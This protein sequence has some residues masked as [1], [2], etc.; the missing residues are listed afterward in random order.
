MYELPKG[1]KT[2]V[3]CESVFNALTA[4]VYGYPAV[5]LFGTGTPAQARALQRLG[6][7]EVVLAFDPDD[8][9]KGGARRMRKRLMDTC[10]VS[11]LD[12]IPEGM[13]VNDLSKEDFDYLYQHRI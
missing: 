6:L 3:V 1:T 5:A 9:G 11:E 12:G 13:D 8:A 4:A 2:V 7:V 10:L